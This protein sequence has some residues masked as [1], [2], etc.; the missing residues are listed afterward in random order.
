MTTS[1]RLTLCTLLLS[2]SAS[3]QAAFTPFQ[4]VDVNSV[5]N[6]VATGDWNGDGAIDVAS[7]G[8]HLAVSLND[9]SGG[10]LPVTLHP[11]ITGLTRL[12][13]DDA[14]SDGVPDLWVFQD[15]P[16]DVVIFL[17]NGDGTFAF[18]SPIAISL[19]VALG[20]A[21][22]FATGDING[23][24]RPDLVVATGTNQFLHVA[25]NT[26]TSPFFTGFTALSGT[27]TQ[28]RDVVIADIDDDGH[29]DLVWST[30][31]VLRVLL[32]DGSGAFPG[33]VFDV[34]TI[35]SS[36][37]LVAG[38]FDG[39]G[40][41][42]F[43][44]NQTGPNPTNALYVML[45]Q[46][47]GGFTTRTYDTSTSYMAKMDV[48]DLD[49]DGDLDI[50]LSHTDG[51]F[52]GGVRAR[53]V[54]N[55]GDGCF[56]NTNCLP[57]GTLPAGQSYNP[58][59]LT[60]APTTY[61][62]AL[63]DLDA[64]SRTDMVWAGQYGLSGQ[65]KLFSHLN[66]TPRTGTYPGTDE[67]L[68][69]R[70]SLATLGQPVVYSGGALND[71]KSAS[72]GDVLRVRIES[73]AGAFDYAPLLLLANLGPTVP[74]LPA[75]VLPGIALDLSSVTVVANGLQPSF[76]GAFVL[77]EGWDWATPIPPGLAGNSLFLQAIAFPNA[78]PAPFTPTPAANGLFA[79]TDAHEI[80]F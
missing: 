67:D 13:A 33:A 45:N 70:T 15:G 43:A 27:T 5:I 73:Q 35:G 64:D 14:N 65:T 80:R 17:G 42:D 56:S 46:G 48:G 4:E 18:L 2:A 16:D 54:Y 9:G 66:V 53:L 24:D 72:A 59:V 68:E 19:P 41:V 30:G 25:I 40:L 22:D 60:N 26:G 77:P 74:G 75:P 31:S 12:I 3:A 8:N 61:A 57:A 10:L 62:V 49:M 28:A 79:S 32:N 7:A 29:S 23:D 38:D 11:G 1:S 6:D 20:P 71:V 34:A 50:A 78:A 36:A 69:M 47:S 52:G 37:D 55:D 58:S 63:V 21:A 51:V 39:N 76:P 44:S